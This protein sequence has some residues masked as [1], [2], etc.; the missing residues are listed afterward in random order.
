MPFE[1]QHVNYSKAFTSRFLTINHSRM[2]MQK[3]IDDIA[4]SCF[5]N[6][7]IKRDNCPQPY[8]LCEIE[9]Y[10]KDSSLGINDIF[11]HDKDN[12]LESDKEYIH[13]SGFDICMGDKNKNIYCGV[14]VRGV[15]NESET[16]FGPRRVK[17][18]GREKNPRPI[19]IISGQDNK[20]I[21]FYEASD[22]K[23]LNDNL[24]LRL[25]RVNLS[26][27]TSIKYVTGSQED[28]AE[29]KKYL[30]LR[31]RYLRI[32]DTSLIGKAKG[33]AEPK[34]IINSLF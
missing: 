16:I 11:R 1:I 3:V 22:L 26:T 5:K 7:Q 25:P 28:Q 4:L 32:K 20:D 33:P 31:A 6:Y 10:L 8:E 13:Y 23:S 21:R 15:M 30:N 18:K 9:I 29:L 14:L 34:E 17:Y 12:H 19:E 24:V 2:T 27:R